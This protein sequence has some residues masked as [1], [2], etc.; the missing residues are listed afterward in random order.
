MTEESDWP[1]AA[2]ARC[3]LVMAA[4]QGESLLLDRRFPPGAAVSVG[5][6]S[7]ND[8]IIDPRFE[9]TAY[10][11]LTQG[12]ILHLAPPLFVQARVWWQG[13]VLQ[14]RGHFRELRKRHPDL[15]DAL[16]LASERFLIRYAS[17]IALLGRFE[18]PAQK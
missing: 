2:L 18:V 14:L 16:P 3:P 9:L 17:G 11:L 12:S 15:P 8:L 5:S 4:L 7:G 1:A 10:T 13:T 6:N